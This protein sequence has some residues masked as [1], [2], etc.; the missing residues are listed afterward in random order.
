MRIAVVTL[1]LAVGAPAAF[2][3][4][5][6]LSV[7]AGLN[8]SSG[9]YGTPDKTTILSLPFTARYDE[10]RLKLKLTIPW[11]RVT[12]PGN[13]VPG[14]GRVRNSGS[15]S[16]TE[17]GLGDSTFAA[18]YNSYYDAAS[19]LGLDLTGKIKF[20]TG[21]AERGLGTDSTD[22]SFQLDGYQTRGNLTLF[23]DL[24]YTVF[25]HSDV[26]DLQ[27][28]FNY[29]VGASAR[30][31]RTDSLGVS[32]DGRQKVT[33]GGSPQRELTLFWNRRV[34]KVS[35]LQAY[36]LFGLADGSP[37]WGVGVSAARSF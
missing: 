28:A 9:T 15:T 31:D 8:Y 2:G 19:M 36:L 24:G 22:F 7:G 11:L 23:A 37:D 1:A 29:G 30:L 16:R 12:G 13:V 17:S 20:P 21:N 33:P 34:A 14:V 3:A 10:E 35:R 18:T 4:D 26:I 32:L 27:N 6:E 25:G 5:G